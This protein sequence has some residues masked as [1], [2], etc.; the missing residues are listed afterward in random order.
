MTP[1]PATSKFSSRGTWIF[2][3]VL[4]AVALGLDLLILVR[5]PAELWQQATRGLLP[6]ALIF[7]AWNRLLPASST[8]AKRILLVLTYVFAL[9]GLVFAALDFFRL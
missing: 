5:K 6:L 1:E 2:V 7:M 3:I 8:N 4:A 9:T